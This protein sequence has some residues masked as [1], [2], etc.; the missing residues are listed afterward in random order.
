MIVWPWLSKRRMLAVYEALS[1]MI[2]TAIILYCSLI[3]GILV[4]LHGWKFLSFAKPSL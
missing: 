1:I 2:T 3:H 4:A